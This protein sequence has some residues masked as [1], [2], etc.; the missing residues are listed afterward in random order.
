[1]DSEKKI[2]ETKGAGFKNNDSTEIEVVSDEIEHKYIKWSMNEKEEDMNGSEERSEMFYDSEME[3]R[4]SDI[5]DMR[6]LRFDWLDEEDVVYIVQGYMGDYERTSIGRVKR[7]LERLLE[8]NDRP[9]IM[10]WLEVSHELEVFCEAAVEAGRDV[11]DFDTEVREVLDA[12]W[13]LMEENES[14][15]ASQPKEGYFFYARM[16]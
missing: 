12:V 7:S 16:W 11:I 10:K 6:D 3:Q 8:D 9:D 2:E 1:M 4:D 13:T 5:D 15:Q 14:T